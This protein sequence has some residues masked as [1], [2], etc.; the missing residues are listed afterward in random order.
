MNDSMDTLPYQGAEPPDADE[1]AWRAE[2]LIERRRYAEAR[3]LAGAAL[4][5]QPR[6]AGLLLAVAR[7]DYLS[8]DNDS[9]RSTLQQLLADDPDSADARLLLH[10]VAADEGELAEA[11]LLIIQ[12]LREQPHWAGYWALYSRLMLRALH[13]E[14]AG[15]LAEVALR[16]DPQD[17]TALRARALCDLADGKGGSDSEAMVQ[18]IVAD[19]QDEHTL[20]LV[21]QSLLE[22]GR[23]RAA[24]QLARELL[25]AYPQDANLLR[26]VAQTRMATHWSMWPLWPL[27]RWGLKA[28]VGLWL[29]A[30]IGLRLGEHFLPAQ[31]GYFFVALVVYV[32]YS[33][34]WP[35]LL[36]R[37]M[38]VP[39]D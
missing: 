4:R 36:K 10:L 20:R 7:A 37:V 16:R 19:P 3:R 25:R 30:V 26:L 22:Q 34:I 35:P 21:L 14:K 2:Q 23:L 9:A 1:L 6:H 17:P 38:R 31:S 13:F 5:D 29:L 15:Q 33:W 18:L 28:S 11:E 12:L 39:A 8:D 27:Q 24:H 32:L